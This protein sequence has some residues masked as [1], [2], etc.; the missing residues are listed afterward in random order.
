[1][2]RKGYI[3]LG[4]GILVVIL[5][6]GGFLFWRTLDDTDPVT[7][8]D[9]LTEFR[10]DP[11]S[12][13]G[14]TGAV[15]LPAPGVYEYDVTGS[16][17]LARGPVSI[18][19]ELP[20]VA[21]MIVRH[22]GGGYETDLRYSD[23]HTE[24]S[25]YDL[26]PAGAYVTFARTVV[27]TPLSTTTRDREWTPP[28]L[29]FPIRPK[30]GRDWGGPFTAGD[31][32]LQIRNEVLSFEKATIGGRAVNA[33]VIESR[34]RI[35]G[36]YTGERTETFWYSP[37]TGLVVKYTIESTLDGPTDFDIT[38]EQTLRSLEPQV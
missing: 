5:V 7:A 27:E 6:A 31:L 22:T 23:G 24:L 20:A 9:A 38:A 10:E 34:Q 29:R 33:F 4:V 36:E 26:R 28:L 3:F 2:S 11:G 1:V 19:R 12:G 37:A 30:V 13:G 35:T 15:G 25:R 18:D 32:T 14:N 8:S 17:Q 21:P 16:E